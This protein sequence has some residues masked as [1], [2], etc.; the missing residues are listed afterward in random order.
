MPSAQRVVLYGVS[1]R[2]YEAMLRI[3]GERPIRVSYIRTLQ[4]LHLQRDG[5]YRRGATSR[6]FPGLSSSSVAQFLK[7]GRT[8]DKTVLIR[9]FRA[10]VRDQLVPRQ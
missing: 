6:N 8:T 4:F 9:S 1:W 3:V 7:Q 10:F 2:D 5:T